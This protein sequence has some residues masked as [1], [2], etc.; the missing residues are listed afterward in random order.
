MG[1]VIGVHISVGHVIGVDLYVCPVT[2]VHVRVVKSLKFISLRIYLISEVH[3]SVSSLRCL[4]VCVCVGGGVTEM[5]LY[6]C[7]VIA[8]VHRS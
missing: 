6:V 8:P 5:H 1:H 4:C 7:L 2:E 3:R